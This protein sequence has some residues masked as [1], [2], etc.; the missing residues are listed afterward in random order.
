MDTADI[1]RWSGIGAQRVLVPPDPRPGSQVLV[2][3]FGLE[4]SSF[5]SSAQSQSAWPN[6]YCG[7]LE[8]HLTAHLTEES[9]DP[10]IVLQIGNRSGQLGL[11][12]SATGCR[13]G[14]GCPRQ[15]TL[16]LRGKVTAKDELEYTCRGAHPPLYAWAPD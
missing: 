9:P 10:T 11:Q 2:R 16:E 8:S 3:G 7:N 4:S 14:P 6:S 13:L 15:E 12:G 5:A 1:L